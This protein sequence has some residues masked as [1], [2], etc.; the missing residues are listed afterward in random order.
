MLKPAR[1]KE[2]DPEG[3]MPLAEHLRELRNRLAKALLAIVAVTVVA[4][5]FYEAIINLLT[6]PIL[7][8]IGCDKSFAELAEARSG[9]EPC[10]QIT[11]NGLL[12][13]FTLALKVSL[14]AGIVLASPVWLYQLWA[15]VAPGLHRNEKK[16][17]YAFVATGAPLFLIGAYF[18]YA[19]LPT[20][21]E[22]LIEF[23]PSDVD[24]LLPL[25]ELL[26]LVTRMV[27]VFG[28]SF[29]LPLLL[30]ML[31]LTGVLTGRRMLGWWRA[32]IMGI[33]LFAAIATPSTDPLTMILLAG[34][35]W[36]LYFG[37]VAVSLVNDRRRARREALEPDDDEASDLDL[38]P[39]SIGEVEAVTTARALPEQATRDRVNGYDDVT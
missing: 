2:R 14:T 16:Y 28:L 26:D 20:S 19:V 9:A 38:S 17:A 15:F 22:V 12:G 33:T 23:T 32:M 13:P 1:T 25:D 35:I 24:N 11:I 36:V 39:E 34:P 3:R 27:I 31:N 7:D 30:V 21:A 18:A 6:G 37:A 29:E 4:A 5:F 8:S 10:A